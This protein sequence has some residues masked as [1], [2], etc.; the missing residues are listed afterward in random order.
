MLC[1]TSNS[2]D[3][4]ANREIERA[5]RKAVAPAETA[6]TR[7]SFHEEFGETWRKNDFSA[8]SLTPSGQRVRLVV[9]DAGC[10]IKKEPH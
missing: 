4:R 8:F 3:E 5:D 7:F 10:S 9:P 6:V 2:D 1:V